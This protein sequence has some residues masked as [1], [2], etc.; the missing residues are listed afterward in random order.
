MTPE[1]PD[2]R[3]RL[4]KKLTVKVLDDTL[5]CINKSEDDAINRRQHQHTIKK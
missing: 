3:H 4:T 1:Q 2:Y 5:A